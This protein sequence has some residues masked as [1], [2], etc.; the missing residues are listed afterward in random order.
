[1]DL[2]LQDK[3]GTTRFGLD[4]G[5][6]LDGAVGREQPGTYLVGVRRLSGPP[7]RSYVRVQVTNLSVTTV[8]ERD[9]SVFFVRTLDAAEPVRGASIVL[10]GIRKQFRANGAWTAVP[11]RLTATTD[12]QG[13]AELTPVKNWAELRR[14]SVRSG[15]D[16]LVLDT[17]EPP[18]RFASN[19]WS[20]SDGWLSWLT[21]KVPPPVNDKLLGFV[22]TERPI[23]KPG[24]PVFI[25]GYVRRKVAGNL[26]SPGDASAYGL[27]VEGP[28]SQSWQLPVK[29]T[30]LAG[31]EGTFDEKEIATGSYTVTVFQKQPYEVIATR[32]FQ[33]EAYRVPTFEV[34]FSG[35]QTVRLDGPFKMKA[36]ARY[37][38]GGSVAGQPIKWKV[39]QRPYYHV[40]KGREGFLFASSSQFARPESARA[41]EAISRSGTLDDDGADSLQLNPALDID[42]SARVYR[43]EATVT[44]PDNQDV[45]AAEEVKALPPF[46][47]GLKLPR[48][49]EKATKLEPEV[50]AVGVDD[51]P[52]AGQEVLGPRLPA[53]LAQPP[54][55]DE[56]R[57]RQGPVRHRAGGREAV[58]GDGEDEAGARHARLPHQ[59]S[60]RLRGGA[61]QPRQAG[62]RADAQRGPLHRRTAAAG[63]EEVARRRLRG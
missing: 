2:P 27:K 9:C 41:P 24:E 30:P 14:L 40:P 31:F 25:K 26:Q 7:E 19:H 55:R 51:K 3:G 11:E 59:G 6:L 28:D 17:R 29:L 16:V 43:F 44:G 61:D 58:R 46:T 60:R 35:P 42:G 36:L 38:A 15:A 39:T 12:A 47:L 32:P 37:Y 48:Y 45:S 57:H 50:L 56:L 62:P 20:L 54:A 33:V 22:F 23:Y 1:M 63:V 18:P 21:E 5:P 10:E 53:R 49:Q 34:R 8:E 4:L 52:L 13:R